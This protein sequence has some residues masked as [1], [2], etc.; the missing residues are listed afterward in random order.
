MRPFWS[1]DIVTVRADVLVSGN[2]I[3]SSFKLAGMY[4]EWIYGL[5]IESSKLIF[6]VQGAPKSSPRY[7]PIPRTMN[8]NC[9]HCSIAPQGPKTGLSPNHKVSGERVLSSR[10]R[11]VKNRAATTLRLAAMLLGK[12]DTPLGAFYVAP[13]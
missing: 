1:P 8:L 10:T 7:A 3:N 13:R 4:K 12:T 9:I 2:M 11:K 6:E 5:V